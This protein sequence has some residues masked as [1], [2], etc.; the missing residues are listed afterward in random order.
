MDPKVLAKRLLAKSS[1]SRQTEEAGEDWPQ[2]QVLYGLLVYGKSEL[3]GYHF[4]RVRRQV[5]VTKGS[6][7][8]RRD[9]LNMVTNTI[10]YIVYLAHRRSSKLKRKD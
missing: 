10:D 6:V 9:P 4:Q 2:I 1:A 5:V 8:I 7:E 3:Y